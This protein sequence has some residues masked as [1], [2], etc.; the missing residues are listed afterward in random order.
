MIQQFF[1]SQL[2]EGYAQ[3]SSECEHSK[4]SNS[5]R[6]CDQTSGAREGDSESDRARF[7]SVV[8]LQ[9]RHS[10]LNVDDLVDAAALVLDTE[11]QCAR[12]D[13]TSDSI[14]SVDLDVALAA[15]GHRP[16]R[17]RVLLE[18]FLARGEAWAC[19]GVGVAIGKLKFIS[20]GPLREAIASNVVP[21][22]LQ[23]DVLMLAVR[24]RDQEAGIKVLVAA[25][26]A[27]RGPRR[28]RNTHSHGSYDE[29]FH[30]YFSKII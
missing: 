1:V 7:G 11:V 26:Q 5:H 19:H 9:I 15:G 16:G 14:G 23:A 30:L 8:N 13:D 22:V 10:G 29:L 4:C 3:S 21:G 20:S 24:V 2:R 27:L 25:V 28:G 17:V 12:E 6:R 18:L